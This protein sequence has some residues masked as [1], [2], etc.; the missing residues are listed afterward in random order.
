MWR[1]QCRTCE[2]EDFSEELNI[3]DKE[4]TLEHIFQIGRKALEETEER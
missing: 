4:H 1:K 3:Y 2:N